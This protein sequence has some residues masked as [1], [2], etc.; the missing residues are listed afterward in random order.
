MP[1]QLSYPGVYV[2]EQSSGVHSISGVATSIA[3]FVGWASKGPTKTARRILSFADFERDCGGISPK[4]YLGYAVKHFF[5]NGGTDAYI[6]RLWADATAGSAE[7]GG[8]KFQANSQ[9]HWSSFYGVAVKVRANTDGLR[10][11][12]AVVQFPKDDS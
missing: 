10:F 2:Q 3:A 7:A 4:S 11:R 5:D 6:V 9:G 1:V 12:V 8:L